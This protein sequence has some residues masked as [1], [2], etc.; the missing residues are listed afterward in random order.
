VS[1][2]T[3]SVRTSLVLL[4]FTLSFT[5]L[6]AAVF[7][8]TKETIAASAEAEKM[9][10]MNE[11]LAPAEYDNA[12]LADYVELPAVAAL[13]SSAPSKLYRARRQGQPVALLFE[14]VAPDGYSGRIRLLLAMRTDGHI[15]AVRVMEHKETPGLGDYIDIR[16]DKNK[17]RPW[18]TQF[19]GAGL[20]T[21]PVQRWKVK[22][23]GGAFDQVT[24]ATISARAVTNAVGRALPYVFEYREKLFSAPTGSTLEG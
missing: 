18:I 3:V 20:D 16:K 12:L 22:K 14:A 2:L 19:N 15:A 6:M 23:D 13:G 10:L 24:G 1:A 5:L 11:V 7:D 8:A 21:V 17:A 4:G 9:K